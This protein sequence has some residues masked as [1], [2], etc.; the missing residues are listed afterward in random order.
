MIEAAG[1]KAAG[2]GRV[3]IATVKG[4]VH[5]IG[6]N[7][8]SIVLQCNGWEV[9]DM[10]VMTPCRDIIATAGETKADFVGLSGIITPSLEEMAVVA[11]EMEKNGFTVPLLIGGATTSKIHT[12]VKIAPRY[13]GP[14]VHVKDASRAPGICASLTH[15]RLRGRTIAAIR[16]EQERQRIRQEGIERQ[17]KLAP[18]EEAR[19]RRFA[20]D[21]SVYAPPRPRRKGIAVF[22]CLPLSELRQCIDWTFFFHAWGLRASYPGVLEHPDFGRE[23]KGL[24][25]DANRMLDRIEAEGLMTPRGVAGFFPAATNGED[26]ELFSDEARRERLG[27][28]VTLRQQVDA[29]GRELLSLSDFIAPRESGKRDWLGMFAVTAG[30]E[31]DTVAREFSAA[32]DD[33]SAVLVRLLADRLAEAAAEHL[34]REVRKNLW[35]YAAEENLDAAALFRGNYRGIRPAPGYPACPDHAQKTLIFDLLGVKRLLGITLTESFAM[36]PPASVCGYLFSHPKAQYFPITR[37]GRDQLESF[38]QRSGITVEEA[39][40]R[41]APILGRMVSNSSDK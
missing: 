5:D 30:G 32:G 13:R 17:V 20:P 19:T 18:F 12:A 1:G 14:V 27:T 31:A 25:S 8:V 39:K 40:H 10:G 26:I 34:H 6:K 15:P 29:S 2:K 28:V 9:I 7:I 16:E 3:V 21:W 35:G 23:A 41:L 22:D 33:F 38:A 37:I 36:D 11:E 4:D 24:L